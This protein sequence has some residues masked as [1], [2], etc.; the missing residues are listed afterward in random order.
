ML[1]SATDW[2]IKFTHNTKNNSLL[3]QKCWSLTIEGE[4]LKFL[5]IPIE[6]VVS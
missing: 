4:H 5:G 3:K 2:N 1:K 6:A